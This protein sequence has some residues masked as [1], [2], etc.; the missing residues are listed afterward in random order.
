MVVRFTEPGSV[1]F[2]AA[3]AHF[4]LDVPSSAREFSDLDQYAQFLKTTLN[5]SLEYEGKDLVGWTVN[6]QVLDTVVVPDPGHPEGFRIS[7]DVVADF[8]GG[9]TGFIRIGGT[10][11]C[12][13]EALCAT[14]GSFEASSLN[15]ISIPVFRGWTNITYPTVLDGWRGNPFAQRKITIGTWFL[16]APPKQK[17]LRFHACGKGLYLIC[18]MT[19]VRSYWLSQDSVFLYLD[20]YYPS[21]SGRVHNVQQIL[22]QIEEVKIAVDPHKPWDTEWGYRGAAT[23][24]EGQL[25]I[26]LFRERSCFGPLC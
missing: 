16:M 3:G 21:N 24:H 17:P 5:A 19:D 23:T 26:E 6:A 4:I 11:L 15:S 8:V 14:K 22:R 7:D 13:N 9:L 2:D 25:G 10:E 1:E 12:V 18:K 20:R